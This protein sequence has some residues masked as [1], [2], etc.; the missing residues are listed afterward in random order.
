MK[1]YRDLIVWNKSMLLVTSIYTIL[2][3]FTDE[4]KFGLVSQIKRSS[5][6]VPSNMKVMEEITQ[7]IIRDFFKLL[8]VH[9]MKCKPK[10]KSQKI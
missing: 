5:V 2:K 10:L 3:K 1:S 9:Y 8:E 4:E 6:S 7:K